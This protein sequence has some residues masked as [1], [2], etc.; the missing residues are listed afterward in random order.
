MY[1]PHAFQRVSTFLTK[2]IC[3]FVNYKL[4]VNAVYFEAFLYLH[5]RAANRFQRFVK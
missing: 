4:Y 5:A 2:D 1:P 3:D